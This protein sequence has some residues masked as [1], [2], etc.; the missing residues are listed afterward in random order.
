MHRCATVCHPCNKNIGPL[1][2]YDFYF[3]SLTK[4]CQ[5]GSKYSDSFLT[6]EDIDATIQPTSSSDPPTSFI[7][8]LSYKIFMP[9]TRKDISICYGFVI[10]S[11][12]CTLFLLKLVWETPTH[13][14]F[15]AILLIKIFL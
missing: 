12:T 5:N 7:T 15:L 3:S 8:W 6:Y 2:W 1:L 4:T 11:V 14:Y 10:W 13:F 9:Q